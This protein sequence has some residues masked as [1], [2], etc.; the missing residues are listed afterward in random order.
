MEHVGKVVPAKQALQQRSVAQV[1]PVHPHPFASEEGRPVSFELD[2]VVL[3]AEDVQTNHVRPPH[4]PEAKRGMVA[5]ETCCTCH[6][7]PPLTGDNL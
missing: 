5:D 2:T 3:F 4:L 6:K 1:T 7:D